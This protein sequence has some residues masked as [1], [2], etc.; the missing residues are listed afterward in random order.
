MIAFAESLSVPLTKLR[1][2]FDGDSVE[3][4]RTAEDLEMENDDVM[5][6]RVID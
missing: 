5:D 6:A 2:L 4:T 3:P 1:F